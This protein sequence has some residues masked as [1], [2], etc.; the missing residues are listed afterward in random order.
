MA[1][2]QQHAYTAGMV[3]GYREVIMNT[4]NQL[5]KE[6]QRKAMLDLLKQRERRTPQHAEPCWVHCFWMRRT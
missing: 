6:E 2:G 5:T 1:T 4:N 3:V